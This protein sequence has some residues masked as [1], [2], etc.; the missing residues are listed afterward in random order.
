MNAITESVAD[1]A[2]LN[3]Q[4]DLG[5]HRCSAAEVLSI[6]DPMHLPEAV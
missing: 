1:Q 4:V 3:W 2:A 5:W 6:I